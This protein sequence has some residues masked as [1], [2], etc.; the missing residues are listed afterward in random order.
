[1]PPAAAVAATG[2]I[3]TEEIGI[4]GIARTVVAAVAGGTLLDVGNI[5]L[6][7]D[8]II[9]H[10]QLVQS[11]DRPNLRET[12]QIPPEPSSEQEDHHR[13]EGALVVETVVACAVA[14]CED[15]GLY[16]DT[17]QTQYLY[18]AAGVVDGSFGFHGGGDDVDVEVDAVAAVDD[19]C[20]HPL[21]WHHN[22]RAFLVEHIAAAGLL[23]LPLLRVQYC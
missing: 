6:R 20:L 5:H 10:L 7:R 15:L 19:A 4:A 2:V 11:L 21:K 14:A 8:P 22:H 12:A 13:R 16:F 9:H 18:A 1:M 23:L 3:A 17:D